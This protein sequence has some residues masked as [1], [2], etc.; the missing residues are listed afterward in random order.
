MIK[1]KAFVFIKSLKRP[2]RLISF[3]GFGS[4]REPRYWIQYDFGL[5]EFKE[6]DLEEITKKEY[7][8]YSV[9]NS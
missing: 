9:L 6:S 5:G 4:V 7:D 8:A 1:H 3:L 2:G